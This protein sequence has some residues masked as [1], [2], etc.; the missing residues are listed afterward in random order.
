MAHGLTDIHTHILPG[1]DDGAEDMNMSL[2]MLLRAGEQGIGR[3]F[4][5]PHSSAFDEQP[6]ETMAAF[7]VLRG[8]AAQ[9]LPEMKLYLG[10]EIYCEKDRMPEVLANL[11]SGRYPTMNG[12]NYVL[13]EFSQWVRPENTVPCVKSLVDAGYIPV[14]AHVERYAHLR[15]NR[16]PVRQFRA[17]GAGLQVNISSLY[18]EMDDSI[19]DWARQLVL[20]KTVDFLGTDAHKTYYRPPE[21]EMGLKWLREHVDQEYA[22]ALVFG[23]GARA[24]ALLPHPEGKQ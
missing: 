4:L 21:A 7:G 15:G 14:I 22:D 8:R 9:F 3:V 11:R 13:M 1:V 20:E 19:K 24:F 5:T 16:E 23:N 12:T 2:L 17:L 18:D 6:E 10:C